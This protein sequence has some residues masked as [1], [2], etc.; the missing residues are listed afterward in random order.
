MQARA[1]P[2]CTLAG[3]DIH[4]V[5]YWNRGAGF[6]HADERCDYVGS[7]NL[8]GWLV[9]PDKTSTGFKAVVFEHGSP[10]A[11]EQDRHSLQEY[12]EITKR[13]VNNG[14]VV[15]WP[16]RR[17]VY[18][19]TTA[20]VL[21]GSDTDPD[22]VRTTG[23]FNSDI[24][25][26][27]DPDHDPGGYFANTGWA[28]HD[29]ALVMAGPNAG[30]F[31]LTT[32]WELAYLQDEASYD[33]DDAISWLAA[34]KRNGSLLVDSRH[35]A[36]VGH[37]Y[38]GAV[39]EMASAVSYTV[40][41]T[42]FASLSGGAMSWSS[43]HWWPY[44]LDDDAQSHRRI[45]FYDRVQNESPDGSL[46]S[47][48]I[49]YTWAIGH[50]GGAVLATYPPIYPSET[51]DCSKLAAPANEPAYYYWCVHAEFVTNS[52][53]IPIRFPDFLRFLNNHI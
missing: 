22:L 12:C 43:S 48:E 29:W 46:D 4:Q 37:S 10:G 28:A 8:Q 1:D 20:A 11:F 53:Y 36:V 7:C 38:G 18:D 26:P 52:T 5:S 47:A 44:V 33:L 40:Q 24:T 16:F 34:R 3:F 49:P 50:G 35:I 13:L 39:A 51:A 9:I 45:V 14:Y 17:G 2:S 21:G 25:D 23:R 15:F 42:A 41:P 6:D 27:T 32:S 19:T 30:D 31:D